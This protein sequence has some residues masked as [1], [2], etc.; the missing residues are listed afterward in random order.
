MPP[1]SKSA[2]DARCPLPARNPPA[3][4]GRRASLAARLAAPPTAPSVAPVSG[5]HLARALLP[6]VARRRQHERERR[7]STPL[8][9]AAPWVI[10][11]CAA[12]Q[13]RSTTDSSISPR[14]IPPPARRDPCR[15]QHEQPRCNTRQGFP[16]R[17]SVMVGVGGCR[18]M[19]RR[20]HTQAPCPSPARV[21]TRICNEDFIVGYTCG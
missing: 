11:A 10:H 15:R 6:A 9:A 18:S 7:S 14:E 21:Q 8:Q 2:A 5:A 20:P 16:A 4:N 12:A 17:L 13:T 3:T 19:S 1:L